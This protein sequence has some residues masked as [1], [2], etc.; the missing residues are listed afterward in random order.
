MRPARPRHPDRVDAR[1]VSDRSGSAGL[2]AIAATALAGLIVGAGG[3]LLGEQGRM[4]PPAST[5]AYAMGLDLRDAPLSGAA[6]SSGERARIVD[7]VLN[8]GAPERLAPP[9][10]AGVP[11][12]IIIFDDIGVDRPASERVLG[13]PGPLTLSILPYT[14]DPQPL[15]DRA[16]ARGYA[17]M[18]H[19][20]MEPTGDADPGPNALSARMAAG[21]FRARLEWN[22]DRVDGVV[23]VNNHMGSKLTRDEAAMQTVLAEIKDRGLFFIDS[24]TTAKSRA[25]QAGAEIGAKVYARD[26][27]I[28][29]DERPGAI[30]KQ[31]ALIEEIAAKT[32]F[33]VAIAHPRPTTLDLIG[34]WLTTLPARGFRLETVASLAALEAAWARSERIAAN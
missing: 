3:A 27:F 2:A 23:A 11:R 6:F 33:A 32:G 16:I 8:G 14:N 17:V 7:L 13:F 28:D 12:I 20:P 18:L 5:S 15:A 19:L 22:L 25:A 9:A 21:E 31:L 30:M 10:I 24:L 4:V 34:P 26:V 1:I 29:A